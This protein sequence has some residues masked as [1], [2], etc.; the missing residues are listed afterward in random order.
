MTFLLHLHQIFR[1]LYHFPLGRYCNYTV[2]KTK[3]QPHI[4][5]SDL[6]HTNVR[7]KK[8]ARAKADTQTQLFNTMIHHNQMTQTDEH[9]SCMAATDKKNKVIP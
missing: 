3:Q 4:L 1:R 2:V 9:R 6:K 5:N 8:K 7:M